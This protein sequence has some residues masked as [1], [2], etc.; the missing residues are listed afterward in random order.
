MQE[1]NIGRFLTHLVEVTSIGRNAI[2]TARKRGEVLLNS[3][4]N[5]GRIVIA[6]ARKG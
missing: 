5:E 3:W 6:N 4:R 2:E 1:G